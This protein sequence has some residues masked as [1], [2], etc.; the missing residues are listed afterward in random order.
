MADDNWR[1][2]MQWARSAD[3]RDLGDAPHRF[4]DEAPTIMSMPDNVGEWKASL[5]LAF[6]AGQR[7]QSINIGDGRAS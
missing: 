3:E 7:H 5:A 1:R 4:A 2:L 6:A